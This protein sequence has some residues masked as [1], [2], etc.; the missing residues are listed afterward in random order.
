[1]YAREVNGQVLDFGVS[2][3]LYRNVLVMY[4]RQTESLWSQLLGKAIIGPMKGTPLTMLPATVM[5][6]GVWRQEHPDG[7]L[8]KK[9]VPSNATYASYP[10]FPKSAAR[11]CRNPVRMLH[12]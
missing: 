6:W 5:T 10:A 3:K 8:L 9:D 11:A 2:G 7:L 12:V 4:D 1:M